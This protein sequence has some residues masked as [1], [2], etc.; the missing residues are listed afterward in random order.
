MPAL[1]ADLDGA[2]GDEIEHDDGVIA[3]LEGVV[4]VQHERVMASLEYHLSYAPGTKKTSKHTNRT[5]KIKCYKIKQN[6]IRTRIKHR[7][8]GSVHAARDFAVI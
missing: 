5:N 3:G 6:K 1:C 2:R 7:R 8:F 4:H